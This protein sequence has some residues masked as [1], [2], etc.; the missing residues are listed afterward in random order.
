MG[1][2]Y[3]IY[4]TVKNANTGVTEFRE[5]V[6]YWRKCFS[7]SKGLHGLFEE[8]AKHT[9][10]KY[11]DKFNAICS[12]TVVDTIIDYIYEHLIY[13]LAS[14]IWDSSVWSELEVRDTTIHNLAHLMALKHWLDD[15]ENLDALELAMYEHNKPEWLETLLRNPDKYQV[16]IESEYS[17]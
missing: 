14:D 15:R 9:N 7:I 2:D 12:V 6:A 10:E 1:L 4:L 5:D 16:F 17:Y 13:P 8:E 3:T 11:Q